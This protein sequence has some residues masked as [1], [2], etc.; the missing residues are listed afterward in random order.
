MRWMLHHY[1]GCYTREGTYWLLQVSPH[2]KHTASVLCGH[3]LIMLLLYVQS[4]PHATGLEKIAFLFHMT[5][6]CYNESQITKAEQRIGLSLK[7]SSTLAYQAQ[8]PRYVF[9]HQ[10]FWY[11]P[12]PFGIADVDCAHMIDLDEA[13]ILIEHAN[14]K[15]AKCTLSRQCCKTGL[16]GHGKGCVLILAIRPDG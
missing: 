4:Y 2:W 9:R 7:E 16:D 11:L 15:F 1:R 5:G 14:H 10:C 6:I 12:Y 8:L 3:D 13:K